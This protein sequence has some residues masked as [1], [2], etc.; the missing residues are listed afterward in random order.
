MLHV[1]KNND[2]DFTIF[3][4]VFLLICYILSK[5]MMK[6]AKRKATN[7]GFQNQQDEM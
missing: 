1:A 3:K 7:C 6:G 2:I 5:R 4:I